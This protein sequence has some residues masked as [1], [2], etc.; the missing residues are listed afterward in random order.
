MQSLKI[1]KNRIRSIESTNKLTQAMKLISSSKFNVLNNFLNQEKKYENIFIDL[2]YYLNIY[3][4]E[5]LLEKYFSN[6]YLHLN[7]KN[8][9]IIVI[10]SD[11]GLCSAFNDKI[12]CLLNFVINKNMNNKIITFGTKARDFSK[13]NYNNIFVKNFNISTKNKKI[14]DILADI[15]SSYKYI[16]SFLSKNKFNNCQII[17]TKFFT[18]LKQQAIC[19]NFFLNNKKTYF[20]DHKFNIDNNLLHIITIITKNILYNRFLNCLINSMVSEH[21]SRMT[22]MD[23]AAQNAKKL[24]AKLKKLYRKNRQMYITKE[25]I[26]IISGSEATHNI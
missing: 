20:Y 22:A 3:Y 5:D 14:N 4:N 10:S 25:L 2:R 18:T 11:K 17:Y 15:I 19:E 9:L 24:T 21:F 13:K 23:H 1:L 7:A 6:E 16:L 8:K 26:E 12:N